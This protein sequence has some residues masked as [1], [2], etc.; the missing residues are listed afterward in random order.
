MRHDGRAGTIDQDPEFIDFLQSLTEP[1]TKPAT[2]GD[3]DARH[4]KVT[5]TPLVQFIKDKKANKAKEAIAAKTAKVTGKPDVK[6]TK[7]EKPGAKVSVIKAT[8]AAEKARREKATQDAV[9]AINKTVTAMSGKGAP[10][11]G[12]SP[13]PAKV[14]TAPQSPVKRERERGNASIAARILQRDLGLAPKE[15]RTIGTNK[16]VTSSS[17]ISKDSAKPVPKVNLPGSAE[18]DSTS[19]PAN[20]TQS[21]SSTSA[22]AATTP[23]GPRNARHAAPTTQAAKP[24][25]APTQR[26]PKS[27]PQPSP[28]AKSAFLKH[29]NPSQGVTE[30]LLQSAFSEF[31]T[32]LR[33]EIDKKKGFGYVDFADT[34]GLKKAMQASP[35]KIGNGHVVV[36]ENK[37]KPGVKTPMVV[38]QNKTQQSQVATQSG[39]TQAKSPEPTTAIGSP[40]STPVVTATTTP[41]VAPRGGV[42]ANRGGRGGHMGPGR[43]NFGPPG[44]GGRGG[45][46][47]RGGFFPNQSR[48]GSTAVSNST[49][50]SQASTAGASPAPAAAPS[51]TGTTET[52]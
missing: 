49:A 42:A 21:Q 3:E 15:R 52:K 26:P 12:D 6:E 43:G 29:A 46:R 37:S 24:G 50:T 34:E 25:P 22:P 36:L 20:T 39:Q 30:A 16:S 13:T 48:G 28:G 4:G 40:T 11:K 44:R 47:G 19:Q 33:C 17:E 23:T 8:P 10:S 18:S 5:T 41:P 7:S 45:F 32:L 1:A 9:K 51:A 2:G 14:T 31:G 35:V 27:N 38:Q